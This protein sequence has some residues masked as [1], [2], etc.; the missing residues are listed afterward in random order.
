MSYR[1]EPRSIK[2]HRVARGLSLGECAR[3]ADIADQTLRYLERGVTHPRADTIARLA[4]V[5]GVT[6]NDFY[7]ATAA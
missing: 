6:P 2:R 5:L 7:K 1:F 4:S 3:R